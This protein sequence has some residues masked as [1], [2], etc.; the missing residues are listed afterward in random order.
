MS[1]SRRRWVSY[2]S[3]GEES[4]CNVGDPGSTPG[5]GGSPGGGHGKPIP[6]FCLGNPMVGGAWQATGRRESDTAERLTLSRSRHAQKRA[7]LAGGWRSGFTGADV[8][9]MLTAHCH[10]GSV[11]VLQGVSV[12]PVMLWGA[13]WCSTEREGSS[14]NGREPGECW[15]NMAVYVNQ[16][17]VICGRLWK[18]TVLVWNF[19]CC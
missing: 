4:A 9:R 15:E 7:G 8:Y 18:P 11:H 3:D 17:L 12:F 1:S 2:G 5:L 10:A 14:V 13:A 6:V 16:K 19:L